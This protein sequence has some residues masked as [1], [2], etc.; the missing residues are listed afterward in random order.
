MPPKHKASVKTRVQPYHIA[1][2]LDD[3][4]LFS[5]S[6][7]VIDAK[8]KKVVAG[9]QDEY[10]RDVSSEKFLEATFAD[11]KM[12]RATE[13]FGKGQLNKSSN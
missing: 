2:S 6:G 13:R 8:T 9:L 10:G 1:F 12:L 5:A 4:Y 7:D 11:G 3:K